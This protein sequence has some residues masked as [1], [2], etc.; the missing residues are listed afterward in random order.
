[1]IGTGSDLP[2]YYGIVEEGFLLLKQYPTGVIL[3]YYKDMGVFV[4]AL[5]FYSLTSP[6]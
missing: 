6:A 3:V 4:E 2:E 5:I 1:M